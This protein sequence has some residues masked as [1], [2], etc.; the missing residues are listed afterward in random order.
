M[1]I[2]S[3][4]ENSLLAAFNCFG[5]VKIYDLQTFSLLASMSDSEESQIDEFFCGVFTPDGSHLIVG[6]KTK[7]RHLWSYQDD[8]NHI[9]PCDIK[10]FNVAT[11]K[12]ITKLSGHEE[13]ILTIKLLKF[14]HQN[15]LISTSQDGYIMKWKMSDDWTA[16]VENPVRFEDGVSCMVF[17]IEFIPIIS[18]TSTDENNEVPL[19]FVAACDD[20]LKLFD[21]E[22]AKIIQTFNDKSYSSY[23]DDLRFII[24]QNLQSKIFGFEGLK[25]LSNGE[26]YIVS[27]GVELV[28]PDTPTLPLYPN[29]I[30]LH[31]LYFDFEKPAESKIENLC[32]YSNEIYFSNSWYM[33]FDCNG[34]YVFGPACDGK[35]FVFALGSGQLCAMLCDHEEFEVR[36]VLLHPSKPLFITC[37][38]D[39]NIFVYASGVPVAA[40]SECC[41]DISSSR[42]INA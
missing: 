30:T 39:G 26:Y 21:F 29:T 12:V 16:L 14:K 33:R 19:F 25:P 9:L 5:N 23:C 20:G 32:K 6:G 41:V 40:A 7:N 38:D 8:D 35:V 27:R 15:Y 1:A 4:A 34:R 11:G 18:K 22:S 3:H 24:M 37:G 2:S 31:K 42:P 13:E 10:I 28:Q 36:Q 17:N